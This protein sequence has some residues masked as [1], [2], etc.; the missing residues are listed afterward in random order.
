MAHGGRREGAGRKA[1][2]G[3]WNE[4]TKVVRIPQSRVADVLGFLEGESADDF[5]IP[6]Y[7]NTV[8]AG[9][10]APADD[11]MEQG[12]N[13][14][15]HLIRNP[16]STFMVRISGNSMIDAGIYEGDEIIVDRSIPASHGKIVVA[17]V[18]NEL[19]VKRLHNKNGE[20]KLLAENERYPDIILAGDQALSIWGVVTRVLHRV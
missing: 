8:Q 7:S 19:T 2:S 1:G 6:F 14:N 11:H 9:C 5:S 17:V 10:P 18:D 12:I 15:H 20:I 13:L 4:P 16:A 3:R